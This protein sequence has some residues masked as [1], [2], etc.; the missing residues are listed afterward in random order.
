MQKKIG[1][2][3]VGHGSKEPCNK[4]TIKYFAKKFESKYP[5]V[6]YAFIQIDEPSLL[7]AVSEGLNSGVDELII[8]PVFLTRG[9]HVDHD[10]P[11]ILGMPSGMRVMA[12][13]SGGKK[14][15]LVLSNPIGAD[16]RIV[17]ILND[18]I[19]EALRY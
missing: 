2:I 16:D 6:G 9:I 18:R 12:I 8:Q 7:E 10:I 13:E 1:I 4:E 17:E 11:K 14:V 5:Y 15:R 19:E 3:L